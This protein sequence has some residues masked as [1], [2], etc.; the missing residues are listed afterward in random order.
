M[1]PQSFAYRAPT[2]VE[3]I[4][5]LLA[6]HGDDAKVLAGGQSLVPLLNM[7]LAR[8]AM[9]VDINR[10]TGLA[11]V[12]REPQLV[13]L[14]ALIRHRDLERAVVPGPLGRLLARA[15]ITIG[16]PPIRARGTVC[17]SLAHAD[18]TAEWCLL[19]VATGAEVEVANARGARRLAVDDLLDSPFVTALHPDELILNVTFPR[20]PDGEAGAGFAER[21]RTAGAFADVA[22]CAVVHARDER[23]E[24]ARI[25]VSGTGGRALLL[26]ETSRYLTGQPLTPTVTLDAAAAAADEARAS[27]YRRA[28]VG[29]LVEDALS[30]A[31]EEV[32]PAWRL[33]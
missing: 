9:V 2:S 18:P 17:G 1:K 33:S 3:E 14:G 27:G 19:G 22:A 21:A 32:Q 24:V 12:D 8:P 16:H 10:V 13:R 5:E 30:Q 15:A 29:V 26:G 6:E 11:T 28:M 20:L 7:R 4:L 31:F 25:S 23:V